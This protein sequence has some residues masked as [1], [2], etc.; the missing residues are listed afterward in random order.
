M[1]ESKFRKEIKAAINI[2]S[3]ESGSNTP[4]FILAEF[5]DN[6]LKAFD[7]AC[8]RRDEMTPWPGPFDVIEGYEVEIG[9]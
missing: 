5:L 7:I 3:M 2:Y 8:S 1:E 9:G 6:C 4:D